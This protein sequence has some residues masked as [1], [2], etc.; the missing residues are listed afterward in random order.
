MIFVSVKTLQVRSGVCVV[1]DFR[2][3][4]DQTGWC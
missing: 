3:F 1:A 2:A 4:R